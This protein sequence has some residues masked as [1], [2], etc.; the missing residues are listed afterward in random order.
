MGKGND[1]ERKGK[2]KAG[3]GDLDGE[4]QAEGM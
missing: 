2:A 4:N 1:W 3:L